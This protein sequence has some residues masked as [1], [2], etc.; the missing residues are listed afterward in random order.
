MRQ[1][2]P[3]K[4]DVFTVKDGGKDEWGNPKPPSEKPYY[5]KVA[6]D[7]QPL[8]GSRRTSSSG[9]DFEATHRVFV[10][11]RPIEEIPKGARMRIFRNEAL[12]GTFDIVFIADWIDHLEIEVV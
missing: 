12:L 7:F 2:L 9:T 6:V 5:E 11:E 3:Y 10:F 8:S 1:G 4:A